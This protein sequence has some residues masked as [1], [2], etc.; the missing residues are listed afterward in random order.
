MPRKLA[1]CA[2]AAFLLWMAWP[3]T[4]GFSQEGQMHKEQAQG[5]HG[6]MGGGMMGMGAMCPM[7][8]MTGMAGSDPEMAARM[9]EMRGEMMIK[10]G[11]V[12]VK[13]AKAMK[14]EAQP[15]GK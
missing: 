15:K 4:R 5:S 2:I 7:M 8:A 1:A 11:E 9:M 10:M 14:R 13:H 12:M 6:M 3:S